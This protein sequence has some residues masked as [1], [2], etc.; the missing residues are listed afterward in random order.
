MY[1]SLDRSVRV[2]VRTCPAIAGPSR[3][4]KVHVDTCR[5]MQAPY[6][7]SS[8]QGGANVVLL[9]CSPVNNDFLCK[10]VQKHC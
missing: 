5:S 3:K 10:I 4:A 8:V 6:S 7:L 9:R 1:F 2:C